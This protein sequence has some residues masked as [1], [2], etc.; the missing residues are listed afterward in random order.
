MLQL[1]VGTHAGSAEPFSLD[2]AR[3]N[4]HTFWCGQSGSGKTYALGVVLERLLLDTGLPMLVLDPNSDFV[5]FGQPAPSAPEDVAQQIRERDVRVFRPRGEGGEPLLVRFVAM[6]LAS[7]AAVLRLDPIA[8]AEEFNAMRRLQDDSGPQDADALEAA[9]RQ[10]SE[11]GARP[12]LLRVQN[13]GTLGWDVWA[14]G[15][16]SVESV[17]EE[18]PAATVLDLGGFDEPEESTTAALAVLDRLWA[19]RAE[20]KPL[21]I[22]IDEAH[23]LCPPDPL[24]PVRRAITERIIQIAAEGRKYG[25]WLLLS[26][27]RPSKIHPQVLSQCDNLCLMK[28][29]G[30]LD[31][32]HLGEFFGAVPPDLLQRAPSFRQGQALFAGGFAATPTIAQ[33]AERF[34]LEGGSDVTVP[35]RG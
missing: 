7:R 24:T 13:L 6:D 28:L 11:P 2:G 20:R 32:A 29:N 15:R 19:L 8:D 9:L 25:L 34:T 30:P 3:F 18:R 4:R 17:I 16:V 33:L 1:P 14:R 26:T 21:L 12:L 35:L 27:Q 10:S 31:L 23:N 5:S 22:V